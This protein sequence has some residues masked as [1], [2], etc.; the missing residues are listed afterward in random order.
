M[1]NQDSEV[2]QTI[3]FFSRMGVIFNE[4][5]P[6]SIKD[7]KNVGKVAIRN[8]GMI[9]RKNWPFTK[10]FN[11]QLL[12]MKEKGVLDRLLVPYLD[13]IKSSCPEDQIIRPILKRPAPIG[14]DKTIC[15]YFIL[16]AGFI[17]AVF[18]LLL[19]NLYHFIS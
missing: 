3:L 7:V 8:D 6:C 5:F 19:E 18:W 12:K 1:V 14:I 9:F 15:L 13:E 10:L 2:S 11:F 16:A 17:F 4:N